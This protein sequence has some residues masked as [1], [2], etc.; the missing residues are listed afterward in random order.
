MLSSFSWV[1]AH[2]LVSDMPTDARKRRASHA[3]ILCIRTARCELLP[4]GGLGWG[5]LYD[6]SCAHVRH[7]HPHDEPGPGHLHGA[8]P[9]GAGT[10]AALWPASDPSGWWGPQ[11]GAC[12]APFG[13]PRDDDLHGLRPP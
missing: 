1:G 4:R 3:P 2:V 9:R 7:P 8:R 12:A 6:D 13:E 10:Q 11:C 5:L